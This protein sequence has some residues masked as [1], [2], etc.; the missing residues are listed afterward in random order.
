VPTLSAQAA[1]D[2]V[3]ANAGAS[4]S[5]DAVDQFLMNE[6]QSWGTAGKTISDETSLGLPNVVGNIRGGTAPTDTDR[7]GMPD[8]W[9]QQNGLNP[10]SAADAMQDID[11]DG[12]VNVEEYINSLAL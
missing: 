9:E 10:Y 8:S 11:G 5:R 2:Y 3:I 4:K 7:D 6:L 1:L 12:W